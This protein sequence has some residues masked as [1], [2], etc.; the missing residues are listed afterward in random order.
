MVA[1]LCR[2]LSGI[3]RF[4]PAFILYLIPAQILATQ[5]SCNSGRA[6][7]SSSRSISLISRYMLFASGF[8]SFLRICI[9]FQLL[10][11]ALSTEVVPAVKILSGPH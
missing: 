10:P 1:N 6:R 3:R 5:G 8:S 9:S 4:P 7:F 2:I 11:G